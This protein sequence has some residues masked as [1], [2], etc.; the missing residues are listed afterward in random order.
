MPVKFRSNIPNLKPCR[1]SV[2][3]SFYCTADERTYGLHMLGRTPRPINSSYNTI[4]IAAS[5]KIQPI[6]KHGY[7]SLGGRGGDH[8][9][10][11]HPW[12]TTEESKMFLVVYAN[13]LFFLMP[14][15]VKQAY[16]YAYNP[17]TCI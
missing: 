10:G 3:V 13:M 16:M 14:A 1:E 4:K 11:S 8:I 5:M 12:G 15:S 17:G 6:P 7:R 9:V 2:F